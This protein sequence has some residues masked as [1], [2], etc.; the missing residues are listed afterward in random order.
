ML[1]AWMGL[2]APET[3]SLLTRVSSGHLVGWGGGLATNRQLGK[4]VPRLETAG[5]ERGRVE[6]D[7]RLEWVFMGMDVSGYGSRTG[8]LPFPRG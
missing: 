2:A 1:H 3:F 4:S 5:E 8:R 7:G 6:G